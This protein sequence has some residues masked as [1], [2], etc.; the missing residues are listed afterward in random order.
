MHKKS[1][2]E[3]ESKVQV[4]NGC[5]DKGTGNKFF[6]ETKLGDS[7]KCNDKDKEKSKEIKV[8]LLF[9]PIVFMVMSIL[10]EVVNF[11]YLGLG[12]LPK[13]VAFDLAFFLFVAGLIYLAPKKW[14][15]LTVFYV[16]Y[17]LQIIIN[18]VNVTMN[19]VFGDVLSL[20]MLKLGNEA[21]SAFSFEF[22]DFANIAINLVLVAIS[23]LVIIGIERK[24]DFKTIFTKKR[25]FALLMCAVMTVWAFC[26]SFYFVGKASLV[27]VETKNDFYIIESDV[28]LYDSLFIKKE[29]FKKFGTYGFYCKSLENL[30]FNNG[31]EVDKA[32]LTKYVNQGANVKIESSYSG[33]ASGDNLIVIMLE[34]FEWFAIDPI[35]TPML[36]KLRTETGYSLENFYGRNKTNVSEDIALMGSM[37]KNSMLIDY[38]NKVGIETPYSLPNLF[39]QNMKA[40]E[41][42]VESGEVDVNYFHGYLETFYNRDKIN[43]AL[44]FDDVIG[45]EETDVAYKSSNFG[46]WVKDSDFIKANIDKFIPLTE[47]PFFS[48]YTTIGTHGSYDEEQVAYKEYYEYFDAHLDEY[49]EYLKTT[50]YILPKNEVDY[51]HLR[52]YKSTAMD[53]DRMVKYILDTLEEKGKLESTTIVMFADHNC[54]YHDTTNAVK[55]IEKSD[56]ENIELYNI[57][58]IIYNDSIKAEQNQTF[59]NTYD[60]YPTICDMFGFNVNSSLM[61]GYSVFSDDIKNSTFVSFLNGTFNQLFYTTNVVDVDK[62]SRGGTDEEKVAFQ[63]NVINFYL[64]QARIEDVFKINYF[65]EN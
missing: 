46:E 5:L 8:S 26:G 58:C 59:C 16:F 49:K 1:D 10:A 62:L 13:Y 55:G 25:K 36:Y 47:N 34:S 35:Y 41:G 39:K 45:L 40:N 24:V 33:V 64:K 19:K 12:I 43:V 27:D 17:G 31:N 9:Y 6:V 65:K 52:N 32:D 60:I 23:I 15:K 51:K 50:N 3:N 29:A 37:P 7:V 2:N 56:Y 18:C 44:G 57:P 54:Y 14:I 21:V 20:D 22:L 42:G 61:Q 28:Y 38:Y 63:L 48:F 53:T 4:E 11:I 30:V